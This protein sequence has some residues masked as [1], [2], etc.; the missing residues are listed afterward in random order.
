GKHVSLSEW[1][2]EATES[3]NRVYKK[4]T[5]YDAQKSWENITTHAHAE[6]YRN[7]EILKYSK[8]ANNM[9]E[10]LS[11]LN[12]S[13]AQQAFDVVRYKADMMLNDK[14]FPR[15]VYVREA[16]RGTAKDMKSKLLPA[17]DVKIKALQ[18]TQAE[19]TR[20]GKALSKSDAHNLARLEAA[21]AHY[22]AVMKTFDDIGTAK[23]SPEDWDDAIRTV[24]GGRGISESINDMADLFK[25]LVL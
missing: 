4:S 8:D 21:K 22:E 23:M 13:D 17:L 2:R 11:K 20:Q 10:I 6:A 14:D 3:W 19:L 7:M 12:A 18:K 16:V 1:Q 15:L 9:D 24:T 25:S 5:G